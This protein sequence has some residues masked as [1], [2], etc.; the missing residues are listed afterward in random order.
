MKYKNIIFDVGGV[1]ADPVT[2][3]WYITPNFWQIVDKSIVNEESI[4][5]SLD[6]FLHLLTQEPKTETQ[7]QE[8]FSNY[9]YQ[10]L[11]DV[12]YAYLSKNIAHKLADD[13]VYNDNK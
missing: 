10:V 4:K 12:N 13:C 3:H 2:G 8:M 9:Y 11:K 5:K 1:L 6:K 7:E